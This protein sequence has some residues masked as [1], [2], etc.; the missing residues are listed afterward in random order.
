[1]EE[2]L[3]AE[4]FE[5]FEAPFLGP[6]V[7]HVS[8]DFQHVIP[9][10]SFSHVPPGSIVGRDR[11]PGTY[12][13]QSY[14]AKLTAVTTLAD[15]WVHFQSYIRVADRRRLRSVSTAFFH[16]ITCSSLWLTRPWQPHRRRRYGFGAVS[17][18]R[19][20][21]TDCPTFF[22]VFHHTWT[23]LLPVERRRC[24]QSSPALL[25]YSFQR[26]HAAVTSIASLR[27]PRPSP[28]KP[29]AI[30]RPRT[31]L[32]GSALLRFDFL[33]GDLVRWLAGE[34]TNRHR[35]WTDTFRRLQ[36]PSRIGQPRRLPPPDFPRA[37]RIATAGVPLTGSFI[38]HPPELEA[39][40][41]YDNHSKINENSAAV[42][43]KFA[44]E[45]EKSFHILLPKFFVSFILGLFLNP[46]QWATRKGK[47]RICVDC[48]NGPSALGSP[49]HSI[50]KPS[51]ANAD[52]CPP[53]YY[54]TS[55]TRFLIRLWSMR[56]AAPLQ[57]I[58]LHCD[59]LEA[60]FR[61]VL[62]HPDMAVVFAYIFLDFLIIPV[63][64]VFGSRSA[65]S[66]FSLMSDIRQEV[67]STV[68][69]LVDG[70]AL[71]DLAQSALIDPL[72]DDWDPALLLVPACADALHPPLSTSERL[73]FANAT[74]VDD[75]GVASYRSQIRTALH[76]SVRAAYL[77]FG[78]PCDDR[79]QSCLSA[80][81]WDPF[82]SFIMLYLGFL[83]NTRDMTVTWPY[84]KRIELR[85]LIL[86]VLNA[87][88]KH[89][90]SPRVIA[91]IIGKIRSAA[92]IAPWGNFMSFSCQE[93]L[94]AAL[95][96][97]SKQA[98]WFWRQGKMRVPA[99][100]ARDLA[101]LVDVLTLKEFH[102]TWTRPIALLIPRTGTHSFLS[103]ASYG[104]LGGW[105]PEFAVMWR[106]MRDDLLHFGFPMKAIDTAGEPADLLQEGLHINPLEF[107]AIILNLWL[108]LKLLEECP[109]LA[110]GYIVTLLSDNTSAISWMRSAGRCQ[111]E[112]IRRLARLTAALLVRATLL[113]TLFQTRH[114]PGVQNDEADCLSRL[115][116][117]LVPSW[118]YV[119][120]QCCRLANCRLCLLPPELLSS[121]ARLLSSPLTA[122]TYEDETTRLLTLE[123]VIL[124]LGSRPPALQSTISNE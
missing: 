117:K 94:T 79:R 111:D 112:G 102:P 8:D 109:S 38:S 116:Q 103:D 3:P 23:F 41:A 88:P 6:D 61:R 40:L 10:F 107:V 72:P 71:E 21:T 47:G 70:E 77:L 19:S 114:I 75:N 24:Q 85:D 63:G 119:I 52:A 74:F 51:P 43:A 33:H 120:R 118:D 124:P 66:Y 27:A 31:R 105:S 67:A 15:V 29:L 9:S 11:W 93:A 18:D 54:A 62:Y 25:R 86:T 65:P 56:Q 121:L 49:N 13:S 106:V 46:L 99:E 32:F 78:F 37:Q 95:R 55:F 123:L 26:V 69:L 108:A 4:A 104:G 35:D 50:P 36:S 92:R 113:T 122:G 83:I 97:S 64:Q 30:D 58:L 80:D 22:H 20:A 90:A 87:K 89:T 17:S 39:R 82:V 101:V 16:G 100:C 115:V 96:K 73:C 76:Q 34:Y 91:S 7:A 5:P 12:D 28:S 2:D 59:D 84:E 60:A 48:T 98:K 68:D 81:K 42:E 110:T 1:M 45:E 44:A 57:D 53:V 14:P